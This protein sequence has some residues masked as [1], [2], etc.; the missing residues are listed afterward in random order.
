MRL[1]VMKQQLQAPQFKQGICTVVTIGFGGYASPARYQ[2][3]HAATGPSESKTKRAH[4]VTE[5]VVK[6]AARVLEVFEFFARRR[7]PASVSDLC[8]ALGYPQS[9]TSVLMK[10][11]F[12]LGY[13]SYD[14]ITRRYTPTTRVAALGTWIAESTGGLPAV[15]ENVR[16]QTNETALLAQQIGV[17]VQFVQVLDAIGENRLALPAGMRFALARNAAGRVLLAEMSDAQILRIVRRTNAQETRSEDRVDESAL[18]EAIGGVR[19]TGIAI[20]E[21]GFM[22]G[23]GLVATFAPPVPSQP[24][25]VVCVAAPLDR[26]RRAE[27]HIVSALKRL[28]PTQIAPVRSQRDLAAAAMMYTPATAVPPMGE[29]A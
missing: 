5:N 25:M 24:T 9:S 11:L 28:V 17:H 3:A 21:D 27:E 2:G 10:S 7:S 19:R 18:M 1:A 12:S 29:A 8:V 6:S 22:P 15:L 14:A 4:R 23:I 13:V 16:R 26:L 20:T